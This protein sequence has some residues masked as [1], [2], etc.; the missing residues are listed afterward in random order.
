MSFEKIALKFLFHRHK[1]RK[2]ADVKK[3]TLNSETESQG[4]SSFRKA[5]QGIPASFG[6]S[7]DG[8][9]IGRTIEVKLGRKE[10]LLFRQNWVSYLMHFC[11]ESFL[12]KSRDS[13]ENFSTVFEQRRVKSH[14][15]LLWTF[16][17]SSVWEE[18]QLELYW[19]GNKL[20]IDV[21][22]YWTCI[23]F[24]PFDNWRPRLKPTINTVRLDSSKAEK[25]SWKAH[26]A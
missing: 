20:V 12:T 15:H 7:P 16:E 10:L 4:K 25:G 5:C 9:A 8:F 3:T 14:T 18:D 26:F 11:P 22:A 21:Y 1:E 23:R 13:F 6:C 19:V 24:Q 2:I 17:H